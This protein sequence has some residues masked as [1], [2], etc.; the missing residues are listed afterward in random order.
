MRAP[1]ISGKRPEDDAQRD[2]MLRRL[3]IADEKPATPARW[4]VLA[5]DLE[6]ATPVQTPPPMASAAEVYPPQPAP[7]APVQLV[8]A[9]PQPEPAV[10]EA[11]LIPGEVE[12]EAETLE[13]PQAPF[14]AEAHEPAV[15]APPGAPEP[16]PEEASPPMTAQVIFIEQA[17]AAAAAP[18]PPAAAS[19]PQDPADLDGAESEEAS[20]AESTE[21]A[22]VEAL[23]QI[24]ADLEAIGR[25]M[26]SAPAPEVAS[27]APTVVAIL[28]VT[29]AL[30]DR[31]LRT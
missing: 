14:A 29:A 11:S 10:A 2:A 7:P 19:P 8:E 25:Y 20:E 31:P 21:G 28:Q 17:L 24:R 4:D 5:R 22:L 27:A 12:E 18:E 30:L 23:E 6:P 16:V 26:E 9:V 1:I 13:Q 15:V 3:G